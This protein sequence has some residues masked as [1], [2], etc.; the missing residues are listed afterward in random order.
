MLG[1]LLL[2]LGHSACDSAREAPRVE[3]AVWSDDSGLAQVVTDLGYTVELTEARLCLSDMAFTVAGEVHSASLWQRVWAALGASR[4]FAHPGHYQG[5]E[6]TG[7]LLGRFIANFTPEMTE[8]LGTAT[9]LTGSYRAANFSFARASE[10]DGLGQDDPLLTHSTL[11]RGR[12][13]QGEASVEF[14]VLVD[15]PIGRELVGIPFEHRVSENS[16]ERLGLR[17]LTELTDKS[18]TL[19]DA[20]DFAALA[21]LGA[22]G[23]GALRI[24]SDVS[25]D[26]PLALAYIA[27]RQRLS[28]HDFYEVRALAE[29]P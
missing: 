13:T 27:L 9:L 7:E 18:A 21:A 14:E 29:T 12:A 1:L 17:L 24:D 28:S 15:A 16:R 22:D 26:S 10:D 23:T 4:A 8:Q 19:F 6:V 2:S 11:L 25:A 5:G 20:I 3:L